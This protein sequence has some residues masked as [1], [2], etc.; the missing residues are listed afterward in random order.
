[1]EK[2]IVK[3][4]FLIIGSGLAGL[5]SAIYASEYGSVNLVSK[6]KF[7]IS[8]TYWAQGGIAAA[9]D[10]SDS[11]EIHYQDTII[12]GG[13]LCNKKM[14]EI[15]VNDGIERV[16]DLIKWGMEFDKVKN[17]LHLGLEGGHS[18]RRILH[19]GGDA[20]GSKVVDFLSKLVQSKKNI[21]IFQNTQVLELLSENEVCYGANSYSWE[22]KEQ[23][24][25]YAPITILATGGGSGIFSRTTNPYTST[26]DGISLA[27]NIG[28]EISD[29]EFLQFHPTAFYSENDQTFLITEAIRGEGAY[30]VNGEGRRFM[31]HIHPKGELAPRDIVSKA[32]FYELRNSKIKSVFLDLTHLDANKIK[33]R[34]NSIYEKAIEYNIDITK[35]L[36]PVSPAAH[37]MIGGIKTDSE[38]RTNI[39]G[40]FAC[41]EVSATGVHGANR[42]ASNSLLECL[43]FAKRCVEISSDEITNISDSVFNK[44]LENINYKINNSIVNNFLSF[45]NKIATLLNNNVGI[46]RNNELLNSALEELDNY[47]N[48]ADQKEFEYYSFRIKSIID[49]SE[50]IIKAALQREESRGTHQRSEFTKSH[51]KFLGHFI[52]RKDSPIRFDKE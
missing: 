26:G 24:L 8:S 28:A 45:K 31:K 41:G 10:K 36:I 16:N 7:N 44:S 32:I 13:E 52:F 47:K 40:L 20:T 46:V 21:N 14:V 48:F 37:Y 30:L 38:G 9:I 5:T 1:M 51:E 22:S 18:N 27:Y 25:F 11:P 23:Y 33:E 39:K 43:V 49:I 4:D 2:Q 17:Q 6:S 12:A 29:M 42:L 15:L 35:N 34:F 19:A 3:S 50:M